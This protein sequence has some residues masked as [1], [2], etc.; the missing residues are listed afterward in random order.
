M[1]NETAE[2]GKEN[3]A[4]TGE[5]R[6]ERRGEDSKNKRN[7]PHLRCVNP[8]EEGTKTVHFVE[9][10]CLFLVYIVDVSTGR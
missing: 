5:I 9:K 3:P 10:A 8:P 7:P 1:K 2:V 6:A 4:R